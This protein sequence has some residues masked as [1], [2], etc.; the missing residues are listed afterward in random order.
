MQEV[1]GRGWA[2]VDLTDCTERRSEGEE[3]AENVLLV[4]PN[5]AFTSLGEEEFLLIS[6]NADI[7]FAEPQEINCL[8]KN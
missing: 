8:A 6:R 5:G 4:F 7:S 2:E 3:V 1:S